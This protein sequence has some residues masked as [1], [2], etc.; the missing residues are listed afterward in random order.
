MT[1]ID[2]VH[3]PY[4]GV[5]PGLSDVL[6]GHIASMVSNVASAKQHVDAGKLRAVGVT[7]R[8]RAAG[9]PDVPSISEAGI[10]G[11]EVLNW[12]GMFAPAGTPAPIIARIQSETAKLLNASETKK[13]L[14]GEGADI[15]ASTPADFAVFVKSEIAQWTKVGQAAK[16]QQAD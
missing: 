6:A 9:L 5:N 4:K 2:V 15:I 3:V 10:K 8:N 1:G 7:S 13:R 16:I 11:Y 12:F 14:S